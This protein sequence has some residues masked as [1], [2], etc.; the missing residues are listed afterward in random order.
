[1]LELNVLYLIAIVVGVVVVA[2]SSSSSNSG[3]TIQYNTIALF[4]EGSAIT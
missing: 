4:K 1:M 3:N 2:G